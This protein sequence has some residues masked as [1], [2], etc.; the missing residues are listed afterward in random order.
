MASTEVWEKAHA[1]EPDE[2][3]HAE[4]SSLYFMT[5]TPTANSQ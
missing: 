3:F 5:E 2:V 4:P 1:L